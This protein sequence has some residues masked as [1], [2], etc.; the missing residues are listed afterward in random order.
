MLILPGWIDKIIESV[1]DVV[2]EA[3]ASRI[4]ASISSFMLEY[5]GAE[6]RIG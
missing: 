6:I 2:R 3:W 5:P 1:H 4:E